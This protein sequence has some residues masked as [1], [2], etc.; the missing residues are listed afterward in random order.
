MNNK[1]LYIHIPFCE[2]ICAYCDFTK[3]F[4]DTK[5]V[6]EYLIALENELNNSSISNISSIYVGGGTPTSLNELELEK[7]LK[8]ISIYYKEG[9][10]YTFEANVENLTLEK[11]ILL[12]KYGVNRI[13]IGVQ[14]FSPRLLKIISRHHNEEKVKNVISLLHQVG[15]DDINVDLIYALPSQTFEELKEDLSKFVSLD[16]THISTYALSV[17]DHT[18]FKNKNIVE[19]DADVTRNMYDYIVSYLKQNGFNRYEVSNFSKDGYSSKHNIIYW[20]NQEY[21]G[22]G[23]GASGYINNIRYENTKSLNKYI[24]GL[25]RYKEEILTKDD[26]SFYEIMLGLRL[27]EG[28]SHYD[29]KYHDK[30]EK[31]L[32]SGLLEK[33]DNR[34]KVKD[35]YLFILDYILEKILF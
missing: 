12:K 19:Q 26:I 32:N 31:C 20:R 35:E 30:I 24:K 22:I 17:N 18:F 8:I 11:I 14:T 6:N 33:I 28:I 27:I 3:F 7:L 23:C 21:Y 10:S 25:Y 4:Y 9:I 1:G 13:S 29:I 2:H 16:V 5:K 15:I 34:I